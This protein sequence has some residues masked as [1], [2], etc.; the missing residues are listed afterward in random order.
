MRAPNQHDPAIRVHR[1]EKRYKLYGS[2]TDR[3]IES[4]WKN[5]PQRHAEIHALKP[6]SFVVKR[7]E[8]VGIVGRNGSGKSTLLQL[9]CGTLQPTSGSVSVNGRIGAMLELGS[10]FNPD[11]TGIENIFLNGSI[12]GLCQQ[13][14]S[15][16]SRSLKILAKELSVPVLAL[17]QLSRAPEQ[18]TGENKRPQLS[19]LRESGAIEQD[20]D[21]ILFIYRDEVYNR[22]TAEKGKAEI[23]IS[24]QRNGPID[25][26]KLTFMGK[27]T[28]FENFASPGRS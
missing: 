14:I 6:L 19:D 3:L 4:L 17:S 13:E 23:I 26:V 18:R 22:D 25:T 2:P 15:Q 28:R 12:L 16:I 8:T 5:R 21:V 1:L 24:K 10:G 11:F 7:G 20:A 27:Y 9:I